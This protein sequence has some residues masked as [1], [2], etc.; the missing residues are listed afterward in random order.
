[1]KSYSGRGRLA[2]FSPVQLLLSYLKRVLIEVVRRDDLER[3]MQSDFEEVFLIVC[4][5]SRE[6]FGGLG[7]SI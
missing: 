4:E 5:R 2:R 1:M 7:E 3:R 6:K